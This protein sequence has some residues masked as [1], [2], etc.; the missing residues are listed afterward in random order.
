MVS[1]RPPKKRHLPSGSWRSGENLRGIRAGGSDAG[2]GLE[3]AE[4]STGGDP[5]T[6]P[7]PPDFPG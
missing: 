1:G 7:A 6:N 3:T 5:V 2:L 4:Y